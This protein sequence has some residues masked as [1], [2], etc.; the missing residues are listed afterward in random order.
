M[1]TTKT[2]QRTDVPVNLWKKKGPDL[3]FGTESWRCW[4]VPGHGPKV[5]VTSNV[6]QV[7]WDDASAVLTGD[8]QFMESAGSAPPTIGIGAQIVLEVRMRPAGA[9]SELWRMRV[10]QPNRDFGAHEHTFQL[11]NDLA[12]LQGSTDDFHYTSGKKPHWTADEIARDVAK[13]YGIPVGVIAQATHKIKK[14]TMLQANP[15]DVIAAAYKREKTY[16]HRRFVIQMYHGKL[17]ITPLRHSPNLLVL[18]GSLISASFQEQFQDNFASAVTVRAQAKVAKP[19]DKTGKKRVGTGKIVLLVKS[20]AAVRKYGYVHRDVWAH[21]AD[22]VAEARTAALRHLVLVGKPNKTLDLT[23]PGIA[24]IRRGD[25][26]RA[27]L[28]DPALQQVIFVTDARHTLTGGD[29]QMDLQFTFSDPFVDALKDKVDEDQYTKATAKA[30][31]PPKNAK[32]PLP[33]QAPKGGQRAN[34]T[35]GQKLAARG[36]GGL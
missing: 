29:Y 18:G 3:A 15:L 7:T 23:H 30:R 35:P 28:P 31:K 20:A 14:L 16:T 36:H 8:M 17:S 21:D 12:I 5:N 11:A 33:P 27:A 19:K 2:K 1:A 4:Y 9:Y 6:E 34:L 24:S 22:S 13:R 10:Q 25:A 32:A 26:I